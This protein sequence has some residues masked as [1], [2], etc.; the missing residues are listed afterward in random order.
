[1]TK[2]DESLNKVQSSLSNHYSKCIKNKGQ[3][4]QGVG[5]PNETQAEIR[6]NRMLQ[7]IEPFYNL[8][9]T[10]LLDIGCGYGR[11]G[12]ILSHKYP[13]I[14]YN[15]IDILPEMIKEAQKYYPQGKYMLDN[16]LKKDNLEKFDFII[17]NGIFT[18]K[19]DE[20]TIF[21]MDKFVK[22]FIKKMFKQAKI[23]IAFNIYSTYVGWFDNKTYYKNPLEILAFCFSE[24]STHIKLDH[25][26][27]QYEYTIYIYKEESGF[28]IK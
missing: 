12:K 19:M 21:E 26:Y 14:T 15:G 28:D 17:A 3:S 18:L 13:D 27:R 9:K 25:S 24:L 10:T 20:P 11:L 1:M 23:G 8:K 16:F 4:A 6:Y 5:W 2:K 22:I 7:L